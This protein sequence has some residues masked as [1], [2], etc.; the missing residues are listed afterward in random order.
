[1]EPPCSEGSQCLWVP[2]PLSVHGLLWLPLSESPSALP[3]PLSVR[4]VSQC[5]PPRSRGSLSA[6]MPWQQ[7]DLSARRPAAPGEPPRSA[8]AEHLSNHFIEDWEEADE[9][10]GDED[11]CGGVGGGHWFYLGCKNIISHPTG[12]CMHACR[13]ILGTLWCPCSGGASVSSEPA[14]QPVQPRQ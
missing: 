14:V 8:L 12:R 10:N 6:V 4:L 3:A 1:M 5:S 11:E 2:P 13:R 9:D 7:R